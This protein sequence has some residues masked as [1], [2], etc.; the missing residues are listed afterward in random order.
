M[1]FENQN[2]S[3]QAPL[4][5]DGLPVGHRI[6]GDEFIH[7]GLTNREPSKDAVVIGRRYITIADVNVIEGDNYVHRVYG[8]YDTVT[9]EYVY[10]NEPTVSLTPLEDDN[11]T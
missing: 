2:L 5:R 10:F 1:R 3:L 9:K 8:H 6:E 4:I 7:C 11:E